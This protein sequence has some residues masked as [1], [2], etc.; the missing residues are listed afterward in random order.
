MNRAM[1]TVASN[2]RL[3]EVFFSPDRLKIE[4]V[5]KNISLIILERGRKQLYSKIEVDG[6][7]LF[8]VRYTRI[9]AG[10]FIPA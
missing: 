4:A 1:S 10:I 7:S 6:C 8:V 3:I 2:G 5:L 9:N